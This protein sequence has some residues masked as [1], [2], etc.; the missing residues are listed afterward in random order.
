MKKGKETKQIT[1]GMVLRFKTEEGGEH[2]YET[3][4]QIGGTDRDET[5]ISS[6]HAEITAAEAAIYTIRELSEEMKIEAKEV[7]MFC[8]NKTTVRNL[9]G[10][11]K[12]TRMEKRMGKL[13]EMKGKGDM[14]ITW[15]K[16]HTERKEEE[17]ELNKKA[18]EKA[19]EAKDEKGRKKKGKKKTWW[20]GKVK[21]TW[22]Y[23]E[24]VMVLRRGK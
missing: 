21:N 22:G 15:I 1:A 2:T 19:T 7:E 18:D 10:K 20:R 13:R 9:N 23:K 3:G 8:D 11:E 12:G 14:K 5:P 4:W 6:L 16:A 24:D 17:Y